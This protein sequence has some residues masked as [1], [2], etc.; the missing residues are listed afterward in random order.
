MRHITL[1][2][3]TL[4]FKE[5]EKCYLPYVLVRVSVNSPDDLQKHY[6]KKDKEKDHLLN[7]QGV[8]TL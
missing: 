8:L 1:K 7:L 3:T 5:A 4:N 6:G 2:M